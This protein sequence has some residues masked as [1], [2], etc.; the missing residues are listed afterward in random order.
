[1][2]LGHCI[3]KYEGGCLND[4]GFVLKSHTGEFTLH[5]CYQLCLAHLRDSG[6][7]DGFFLGKDGS[8]C[9]LVKKGCQR[10]DDNPPLWDYYEM[11]DCPGIT[12]LDYD[13]MEFQVRDN[14]YIY[15][16]FFYF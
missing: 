13:F 4:K 9:M 16:G 6:I 11:K 15:I 5:G 2:L 7:C 8:T 3:R 14:V 1:M 12:S 10:R